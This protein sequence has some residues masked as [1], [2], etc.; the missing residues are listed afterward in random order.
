MFIPILTIH[1]RKMNHNV[2]LPPPP[3]CS[4][5]RFFLLYQNY[6]RITLLVSLVPRHLPSY[7]DNTTRSV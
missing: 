3:H 2:I 4:N 5:E 6:T 7:L 1:L